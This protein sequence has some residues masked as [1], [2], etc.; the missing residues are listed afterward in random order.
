MV[1]L[2]NSHKILKIDTNGN[3]SQEPSENR[4]VVNNLYLL[5]KTSINLIPKPDKDSIRKEYNRPISPKTSTSK[6]STNIR[7]LNPAT[8]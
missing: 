7:K 1:S 3:F 8:Q 4:I 5:Y 2:E 6:S